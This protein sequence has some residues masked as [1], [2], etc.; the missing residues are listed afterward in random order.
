LSLQNRQYMVRRFHSKLIILVPIVGT[1]FYPRP[2]P[3]VG[4]PKVGDKLNGAI[5]SKQYELETKLVQFHYRPNFVRCK[6]PHTTLQP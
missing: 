1:E 3:R 5:K 4:G 2:L 6:T